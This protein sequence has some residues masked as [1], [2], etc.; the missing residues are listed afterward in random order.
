MKEDYK[1]PP[2]GVGSAEYK[3]L[4]KEIDLWQSVYHAL[5]TH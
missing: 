3:R 2:L 5:N 1:G 4:T